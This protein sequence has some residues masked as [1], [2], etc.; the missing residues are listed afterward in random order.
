MPQ[1]SDFFKLLLRNNLDIIQPESKLTV[2]NFI[3]V[4]FNTKLRVQKH[5]THYQNVIIANFAWPAFK[6]N[7]VGL[8]FKVLFRNDGFIYTCTFQTNLPNVRVHR[9]QQ[10]LSTF[11]GLVCSKYP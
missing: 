10:Y 8:C 5:N 1:F 6:L 9:M 4:P 2:E 11:H 3:S 7:E